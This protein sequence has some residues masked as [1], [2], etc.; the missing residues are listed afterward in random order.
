MVVH[1]SKK[2]AKQVVEDLIRFYSEVYNIDPELPVKIAKAES[3]FDPLAKNAS[4]TASGVYQFIRSTWK[5]NCEGDVFD[6]N[7]NIK[8][9]VRLISE[10]KEK[11]WDA[12]KS[13]WL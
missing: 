6:Y 1:H 4:S 7:E 11:H 12:S 8:C 10:G 2:E 9:A 3:G 5:E 13:N